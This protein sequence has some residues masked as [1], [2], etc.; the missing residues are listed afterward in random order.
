[1]FLSLYSN[2]HEYITES[3]PTEVLHRNYSK[4]KQNLLRNTSTTRWSQNELGSTDTIYQQNG[5]LRHLWAKH[6]TTS[7]NISSLASNEIFNFLIFE[8]F[9]FNPSEATISNVNVEHV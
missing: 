2:G 1:M 8:L 5:D 4:S 6:Q 3:K 9:I 7:I